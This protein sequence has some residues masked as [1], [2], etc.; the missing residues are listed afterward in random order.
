MAN[1]DASH[2]DVDVSPETRRA[3]DA[4]SVLS[5]KWQPVVLA[6]LAERSRPGFNDLLDAVPGLSGK[7]LSE[8]LDALQEAGL[9]ERRVV[10]E[11]PLRVEY[12]LTEAGVDLQPVFDELAAW[13]ERHGET[14]TPTVL[15]AE[16]DDRIAEMYADWLADQY[17]VVRARDGDEL[18][19]ALSDPVDIAIVARRL[20]GVDSATVTDRLDCRT[21]LLVDERPG[22]DVLDAAP[23][24][25]L[26]TPLVRERAVEAVERQF[27]RQGEPAPERELGALSATVACLDDAYPEQELAASDR[28]AT[29]RARID[30]LTRQ[31]ERERS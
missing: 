8:T 20:T 31:L 6:V 24:A 2:R 25:I 12:A 29:A 13:S 21:I 3:L 1:R 22:L 28:Y 5:Q 14:A 19:A 30:E 9:V 15:I 7:V 23:D 10:S 27:S 11:S 16:S 4:L 17:S 26:S 18:D